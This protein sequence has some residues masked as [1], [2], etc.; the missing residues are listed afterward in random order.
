MI[1]YD[2]TKYQP[3]RLPE[4]FGAGY[5]QFIRFRG[6]YRVVKGSRASK[7]SAT[8]ALDLIKNILKYPEANALVVRKVFR[9]L[10]DSCYAQLKWAARRLK[11]YHLFRFTES[12]LEITV[13]ATGQKILFRG[14]DDPL[15]VTSVAV[16]SGSLCWL[17]IEEAY[18]ITN[19]EDFDML[20]ESI[21]G[22]LPPNLWHQ[23]TITFNPWNERHW[24][25]K[26]FFDTKSPDVLALTTNYTCN[27]FLSPSDIKVFE[28]MKRN[29]PR[30][31]KVAGLGDWGI[32]EGLVYENWEEQ[33]FDVAEISKRQYV[34]SFFGLDFGFT[35]DP[36]ALFCGL[37]DTAAK[38]IYVFDEM[39]Q[40]GLT[41]DEIA[42]TITR[43]GYAKE[44][45]RA[46]SAEPKSIVHLRRLGLRRITAALKGKDSVNAGIQVL[47]DY[48]III[49]P[50]CVNF[51]TE[52]MN[53]A[54]D[55]DKFGKKLNKPIDDFN[56][57]MD[58]M[59]YALEP[60]IKIRKGGI[61]FGNGDE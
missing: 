18:E 59:R 55:E 52:I 45:I 40:K 34:Q 19:E 51:I 49:H 13:I 11:C 16:E 56:H 29:N 42:E 10:K 53:Y 17:W 6:R 3:V 8:A 54:W 22:Q 43:M 1:N 12:P 23:I 37:V 41:N 2:P 38:E 5:G 58:A 35:N 61:S 28:D 7:K 31:Y 4:I 36:S 27:E 50:R 21:R 33:V 44:R 47:Q 30:R 14:L 60:L 26:R 57:L 24:L 20:N 15:K 9:T 25:K 32:V 48:K 39:Y 46:D